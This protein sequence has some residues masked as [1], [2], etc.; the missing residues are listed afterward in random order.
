MNSAVRALIWEMGR[1][2]RW[3]WLLLAIL[4][5]LC[6]GGKLLVSELERRAQEAESAR[7][8]EGS[9]MPPQLSTYWLT[10]RGDQVIT[11][12]LN[13]KVVYDGPI[14]R[15]DSISW[16]SDETHLHLM[17][18]QRHLYNGPHDP[19]GDWLAW[20]TPTAQQGRFLLVLNHENQNLMTMPAAVEDWRQFARVW[21]VVLMG[22]SVLL[23]FVIFGDTEPQAGRGFTGMPPRRFRLPV[24]TLTLVAWP[25]LLGS[26]TI[27]ALTMAWCRLVFSGLLPT[28]SPIPEQYLVLELLAGLTLFQAV[29]WGLPSFPK[30]RVALLSLLMYALLVFASYRYS[31]PN[32]SLNTVQWGFAVAWLLG[33]TA[34]YAGVQLERQGH[35]TAWQRRS[36]FAMLIRG[37]SPKPLQLRSALGTQIWFEWKRNCRLSL[38]LWTLA[39]WLIVWL[40]CLQTI[41]PPA[42]ETGVIQA[43]LGFGLFSCLLGLNLGRDITSK[44]LSLSS[45]MATRP[46]NTGTL[47]IAKL[48]AGL[49]TWLIALGIGIVS[50]LVGITVSGVRD[51]PA[52][53][54]PRDWSE[55]IFWVIQLVIA[56][57]FFI[58]ILPLCLSGRIRGIPWSLLPLLLVIGGV[59]NVF[60]W[61]GRHGWPQD[62]ICSL[63]AALLV[64]KLVTA[65]WGFRR[66]LA[67]R[68]TSPRFVMVCVVTWLIATTVCFS[69]V[70][71]FNTTQDGTVAIASALAALLAVPLAR[72][73]ISPVTLA[74]NRHR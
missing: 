53:P 12:K 9:L 61:L 1:K 52:Y 27:A 68:L 11:L 22:V 40:N 31:N 2:H 19:R 44:E 54:W 39:V 55:G 37:I 63:L 65:F 35:W 51:N 67:A 10:N 47:A 58:G 66:S 25:L 8:T 28:G 73:A 48:V 26:L 56:L 60:W 42:I 57:Q 3:S 15:R 13:S 34:A 72:I 74:W 32:E 7:S 50:V 6:T 41:A 43:G 29:V 33:G 69:M 17:L 24:R 21:G 4:L 45:F 36:R 20:S 62:L 70:I 71:A 23:V 49:A 5:A 38:A 18:N 64:L 14:T 16:T 59:F 30:T 46:V